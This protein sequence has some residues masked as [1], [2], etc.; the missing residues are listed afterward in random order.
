MKHCL[1]LKS[2]TIEEINN[3]LILARE[4]RTEKYSNFLK[5]QIVINLFFEPSTRTQYSFNIAEERLGM[6]VINFNPESSSLV[7]GETF[8]DTIKTFESFKPDALV[9]RS[10]INEYYL[11]LIGKVNVP[12]LNAGDGVKGHPSQSLLDLYTI[13][14]EFN[15]FE[16][17]NV[18]IIGDI[19]HS[20]VAHTNIDIM[21][22]LKMNVYTSG[23]IEFKDDNYDYI[24]IDEAI[25]NMDIIM[26]LRVQH[27]RHEKLMHIS[28][29]EYHLNYGITIDRV[30]MMKENAIIMHP[31]PFNRN[32]EIAD[33]VVECTKSRIFKQMENGVY[34][35]MAL[36]LRALGEEN[37]KII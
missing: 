4:C 37:D 19:K 32:V 2:L 36:L 22:R 26:L 21:K 1:N 27:E 11:D 35:R 23:P 5:N 9:I 15:R 17:L 29:E 3:I 6:K 7:K 31:A 18:C 28:K 13:Y 24:E 10:G 12:I 14:D 8:Y 30:N 16:G 33:D 25:K 20:R 34:I